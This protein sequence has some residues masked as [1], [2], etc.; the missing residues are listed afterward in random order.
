MDI[1]GN[2]RIAQTNT[3]LISL[4]YTEAVPQ[5][6]DLWRDAHP[7]VA[8]HEKK[9]LPLG[10]HRVGLAPGHLPEQHPAPA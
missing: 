2:I 5:C 3:T 10:E 6:Q 4:C 1:D 8:E 9:P 7:L